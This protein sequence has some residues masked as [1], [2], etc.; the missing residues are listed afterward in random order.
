MADRAK[1]TADAAD[2]LGESLSSA[3]RF[4]GGRAVVWAA[5]DAGTREIDG[6]RWAD[7]TI[8]DR[9]VLDDGTALPPPTPRLFSP[10]F[11]PTDPARRA[12]RVGGRRVGRLARPPRRGAAG[13]APR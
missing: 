8:R 1:L 3:L 2:R 12:Y 6:K 7:R 11:A 9:P 10:S 4:G 13:G 5:D